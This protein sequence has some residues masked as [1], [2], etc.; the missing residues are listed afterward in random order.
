MD[1][2]ADCIAT[3][4][5]SSASGEEGLIDLKIIEAIKQSADTGRMVRL[6]W[7]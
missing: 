7:E 6:A 4:R 2:F 5:R 3:K 1:D